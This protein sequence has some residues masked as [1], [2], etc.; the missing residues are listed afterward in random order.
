MALL[1]A[2]SLA[3]LIKEARIF[4]NQ[5]NKSNS[6]WSDEELTMYLNDAVRTYF[7]MLVEAGQGQFDVTPANLDIVA[8]Q[9]EVSLPSG[10]YEVRAVY[11][12]RTDAYEILPFVNNV[13]ENYSTQG[14]T[15]AEAYTPSYYFRGDALV[16]HP[17]PQ[18]SETAG[19]K[20]EYSKI[21]DTMIWGGD[22]LN[23]GISPVFKELIITYCAYKAK[24]KESA[25]NGGQG[26]AVVGSHLGDLVNIFKN[27][28]ATRSNYPQAIRPFNV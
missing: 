1:T 23:T 5:P 9:E 11:K 26:H 4:L 19:L 8:G 6:F 15:S 22:T 24:L 10:C 18:F 14:G 7:T 12:K 28:I 27:A 20:V 25:V 3:R 13:T 16:L 21:P 2:P 17:V